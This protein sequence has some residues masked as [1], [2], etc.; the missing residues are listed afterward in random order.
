MRR[1]LKQLASWL[2]GTLRFQESTFCSR[3]TYPAPYSGVVLS[4]V[5]IVSVVGFSPP[6]PAVLDSA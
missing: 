6:P 4:F 5:C 2:L 3:G 1:T